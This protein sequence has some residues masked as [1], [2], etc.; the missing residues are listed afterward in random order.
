MQ[1]TETALLPGMPAAP[2]AT[3]PGLC[4]QPCIDP[5]A[6]VRLSTLGAW[7]SIGARTTIDETLFGDYSYVVNDSSIIYADIGKFCSI[8]AHTRINPGNHPLDRPALH[9]FTYRSLAYRLDAQDD[10]GFFEWRRR[11]K[12]TLANDVWIGHGAVI[13]PGVTIG[14]GACVGAGAVVS[15]DVP[16]FAVVVGVPAKIIRHR[17]DK[18]TQDALLRIAWWDWSREQLRAALPDFRGLGIREFVSKYGE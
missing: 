16:P 13:L 2:D 9:H 7:T 6:H 8:A 11:H 5:S 4:E 15:K 3:S 10:A 12:V 1:S 17:F 14:T 18:E